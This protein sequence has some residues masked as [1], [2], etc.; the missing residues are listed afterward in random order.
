MSVEPLFRFRCDAP[1]CGAVVLSTSRADIPTGWTRIRSTDHLT[2]SQTLGRG[3]RPRLEQLQY[4]QFT[5]HL[6]PF[7]PDAFADHLPRTRSHVTRWQDLRTCTV[8]CSCG[9]DL[10]LLSVLTRAGDNRGEP[11]LS[12]ER[13]WWR[14]LPAGLKFYT[15]WT[16]T[17]S[18]P[19]EER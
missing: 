14:H 6:C 4:G 16:L 1:R 18:T 10:G 7:H 8:T 9:A 5:L 15:T 13:A 11:A 2:R 19:Q 3:W 12:T 17:R